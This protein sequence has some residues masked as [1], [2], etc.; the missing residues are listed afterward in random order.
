MYL[1]KSFPIH[2]HGNIFFFVLAG[3]GHAHLKQIS[4]STN[5]ASVRALRYVFCNLLFIIPLLRHFTI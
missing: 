2:K 1:S 4:D 5:G 3:R